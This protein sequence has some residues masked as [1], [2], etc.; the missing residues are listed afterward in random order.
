MLY[1]AFGSNLDPVQMR[2]RCPAHRVVGMAALHDHRLVF[3]RFSERWGG[4]AAS[5]QPAHGRTVWGVVYDLND[6][7]LAR[8]DGFE[9]F[10]GANDPGSAYDRRA[11][12]VEL[13]R[14]DD[15]S[16]PR[17][18]RAEIYVARPIRPSPPSGRYRD[19]ILRGAR[20]HRLPDEAIAGLEALEVV[21]EG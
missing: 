4:G 17:R 6:E 9:H 3:P 13:L 20:H 7:D 19:A 12:W 14:A 11:E 18:L 16:I 15:G 8:L 2:E 10:F 5:V 1:F 21:A